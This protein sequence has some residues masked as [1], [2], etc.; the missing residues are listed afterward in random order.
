MFFVIFGYT[1]YASLALAALFG[2]FL[3]LLLFNRIRG[4][5][6]S[7]VAAEDQFQEEVNEMLAKKDFDG[8]AGMC[9]SPPYWSKAVPQMI[10]VALA[11]RDRPLKKL[12]QLLGQR[13]EREIVADLEYGMSWINT[14]V[15]SAPMLG[16]L[17][18][19]S[20]MIQ[21]FAKIATSK[22]G[23]PT[24]LADD[25]SFALFT[26]ALGLTVAIPLVVAGAMLHV[27]IGKFQDNVQDQLGQFLENLDAVSQ[28]D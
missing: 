17:G 2:V 21:A 12:Q 1:I 6:F 13:F 26:T 28:E 16:L 10:L 3:F 25:I 14:V 19:V 11:N 24:A 7:N 9:D 27:R 22:G 8:I 23:D 18:T 5:R 20:G 15:K 4:K